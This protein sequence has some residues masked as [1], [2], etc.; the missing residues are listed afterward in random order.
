MR[1]LDAASG[2][3]RRL[4]RGARDARSCADDA[5]PLGVDEYRG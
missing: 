1:S 5:P 4:A 2:R 3:S